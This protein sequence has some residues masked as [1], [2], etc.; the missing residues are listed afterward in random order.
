MLSIYE[1][2]TQMAYML[3]RTAQIFTLL[4]TIHIVALNT[5]LS[6]VYAI[7]TVNT[8]NDINT[9]HSI[10]R[11]THLGLEEMRKEYLNLSSPEFNAAMKDPY[12]KSADYQNEVK[13]N[14]DNHQKILQ[15]ERH[16]LAE[17][18]TQADKFVLAREAY[19][20][21]EKSFPEYT[22]LVMDEQMTLMVFLEMARE[23]GCANDVNDPNDPY[24]MIAK[25]YNFCS[26]K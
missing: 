2:K 9:Y 11:E 6:G 26:T 19:K 25:K 3:K 17:Y 22:A 16:V 18:K 13:D 10:M 12:F 7:G 24:V 5:A 20:K 4:V 1:G 14:L 23:S 8:I 15:E 21:L